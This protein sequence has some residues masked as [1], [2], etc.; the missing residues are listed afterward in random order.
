MRGDLLCY[1]KSNGDKDSNER[2]ENSNK[3]E[4]L[5]LLAFPQLHRRFAAFD[6]REFHDV[7]HKHKLKDR[8]NR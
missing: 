3:E 5:N 4:R 7:E 8:Q 2:R 1:D 6:E